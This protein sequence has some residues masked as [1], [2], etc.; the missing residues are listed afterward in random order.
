MH[1]AGLLP[2]LFIRNYLRAALLLVPSACDFSLEEEVSG[3][4]PESS[5]LGRLG[6]MQSPKLFLLDSHKCHPTKAQ[7]GNSLGGSVLVPLTTEGLRS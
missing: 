2:V 4:I 7:R 6:L 5:P 1:G 3:I